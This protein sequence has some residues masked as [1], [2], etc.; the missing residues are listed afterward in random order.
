MRSLRDSLLLYAVTDRSWLNG[1]TLYDAVAEALE[2]GATMVQLREKSLDEKHF[3]EEAIA[4]KPLCHRF[5]APLIINDNVEL[6]LAC[7]ADGVHVG[8]SDM[9]LSAARAKLGPDRIIG[10]SAHSV[11]EARLAE[12]GGADYLG[13]GAVFHTGTKSN[14][15]LLPLAELKRITAAVSIPVVAIGGIT[16]DNLPS[17]KGSGCAGAAL[18]SAIF[19]A[20]DIRLASR[21]LLS[22]AEDA[23]TVNR[24]KE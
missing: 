10:V 9:E 24:S 4:L 14:V 8:Q 7:G 20:K 21:H 2:G 18:V 22:L 3:L 5:G 23:F 11:E 1:R 16:A 13:S 6:A 19:A 17:L 12:A 15:T